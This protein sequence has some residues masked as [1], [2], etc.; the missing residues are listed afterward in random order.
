MAGRQ[1]ATREHVLCDLR[2]RSNEGAGPFSTQ[3]S[4]PQFFGRIS[5]SLARPVSPRI[6]AL[7]LL[8]E[9]RPNSSRRLASHIC[10]TTLAPCP[11]AYRP[12]SPAIFTTSSVKTTQ[13]AGARPSMRSGP[14]T[15]CSMTPKRASTVA[16]TRSIASRARSGLLTLTFD[17]SQL[18]RLR[19]W[20][21]AG[22]SNGYRA[23]LVRRQLT[24]GLISSLSGTAGLP[25]FISFSTSYPDEGKS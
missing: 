6:Q 18:P 2:P 10:Y 12:C 17:I 22:G 8:L 16:A 7:R 4:G 13:R 14:K 24:P 15:A 11:T 20:G 9:I 5:A 1:G 19:N 21:I 23:L 25:P 3:P